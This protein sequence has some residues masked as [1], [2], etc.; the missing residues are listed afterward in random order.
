MA[1]N[2]LN[3]AGS[4]FMRTLLHKTDEQG[5]LRV[6]FVQSVM[7]FED[8]FL[9]EDD[10][11]FLIRI[12][13]SVA[14]GNLVVVK[15]A[16]PPKPPANPVGKSSA[17]QSGEPVETVKLNPKDKDNIKNILEMFGE[18][19][20]RAFVQRVYLL[21]KRDFERTLEMFIS[22]NLPAVE[23]QPQLTIIETAPESSK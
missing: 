14:R 21:N 4:R 2:E 12:L 8:R 11:N 19:Y 18:R 15:R 1:S 5:R 7:D 16:A 23:S 9:S 20:D 17:A 22:E 3:K 13:K 6:N 10:K